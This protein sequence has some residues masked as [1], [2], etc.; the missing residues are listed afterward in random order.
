MLE[1]V[2]KKKGKTSLKKSRSESREKAKKFKKRDSSSSES[3]NDRS[4]RKM[5]PEKPKNIASSSSS[6][7]ESSDIPP[8][9]T[10]DEDERPVKKMNFGLVSASG[11]K[12]D[13]QRKDKV[14]I[15]TKEELRAAKES[16]KP[17]WKKPET[18][19][20]TEDEIEKR[21][22][23]MMENADWREK[24]RQKAVKRYRDEDDKEKSS[25]EFDK[26][27][28]NRQLKS[29]QNQTTSIE[30]RIKSNLNKIQRSKH[31]M[32]SNFAKR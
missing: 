30:S 2:E 23:E 6:D 3:D 27:F 31:N 7:S 24:D 14:K 1:S 5:L 29:A 32:D 4:S 8:K 9:Y 18:K 20:L 21:R 10:D 12:L 16:A 25:K 26:D 15:Y 13:L 11:Q 19:K 22:L 17:V 28:I